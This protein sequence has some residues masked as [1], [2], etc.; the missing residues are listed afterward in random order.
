MFISTLSTV[1]TAHTLQAA[2]S[3]GWVTMRPGQLEHRTDS[4][5]HRMQ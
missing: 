5:S 3:K 2:W 4:L 1:G